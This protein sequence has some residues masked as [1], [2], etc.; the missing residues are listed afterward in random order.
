MA[1]N[2]RK[3]STTMAD[4]ALLAGVSK[5]TV[6]FV[7][8]NVETAN[9]PP[10]T[11]ERVLAAVSDLGYR[12][13]VQAQSLRTQRSN[14]YGFISDEIA[15]T[16]HA[17]RIIE[18]AQDTAWKNGKILMLVNTK[19]NA[20]IEKAGI[21]SLLDR[22]VEGIIYATMYHR[23]V[24][25]PQALGDFPTVLLD[26]Y[27]EDRRFP[28]TVPDE[29]QGGRTATEY[30]LKKGHRRIGFINNIDPIPATAGRM[31]GYQAALAA[32]GVPFDEALVVTDISSSDGGYRCATSLIQLPEP[33]TAI[34]CFSDGMA[35]GAYDAIRKLGMTIPDQVAVVG[36]DNLEIIAAHLYPPLTTM[37]LP[38]YE[39][40]VWAVNQLLKIIE[41]PQN[42]GPVQNK[43]EC[44]LIE[45]SSA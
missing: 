26:C 7:I 20:D 39:M 4:V 29:V 19:R 34:F 14:L 6:S 35:M 13:N 45:R 38:H 32:Y 18:G 36:F 23:P 24:S 40:G 15:I 12:P 5:T 43:I 8:N 16:P 30:L 44:K 28:S 33:P 17:G 41:D 2:S 10:E 21:E 27:S 31:Q 3:K 25:L 9:I 22:K 42:R 11:R 37:A 1:L